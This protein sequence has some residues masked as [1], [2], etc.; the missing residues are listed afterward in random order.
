[1]W[2][3]ARLRRVS[4]STPHNP[5]PALCRQS[6]L[7]FVESVSAHVFCRQCDYSKK[8]GM[9]DR[10][11]SFLRAPPA[12]A[13]KSAFALRDWP[14]LKAKLAS[15]RLRGAGTGAGDAAARKASF[16]VAKLKSGQ[17]KPNRSA[18]GEPSRDYIFLLT[19]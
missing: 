15:L 7:P 19:C 11:F 5:T 9:A 16:Q 10:P 1:M 14:T 17:S 2:R 18:S 3:R 4:L 13:T 8:H 6:I 12:G